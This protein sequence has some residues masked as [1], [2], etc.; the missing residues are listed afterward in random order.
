MARVET[1]ESIQEQS[2]KINSWFL[3]VAKW[4]DKG[5][6]VGLHSEFVA[7]LPLRV[8]LKESLQTFPYPLH[9]PWF[10]IE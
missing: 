2:N 10:P 4:K 5:A 6:Y 1:F 9:S 8:L 3:D 7:E